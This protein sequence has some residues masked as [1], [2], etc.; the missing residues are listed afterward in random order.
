LK[1]L[2]AAWAGLTLRSVLN[3]AALTRVNEARANKDKTRFGKPDK[4]SFI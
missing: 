2:A 3:S 1:S 4:D